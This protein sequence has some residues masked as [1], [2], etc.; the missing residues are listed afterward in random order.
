MPLTRDQSLI[1]IFKFCQWFRY[2]GHPSETLFHIVCESLLVEVYNPG[3]K[4]FM[5][6][7]G[8]TP[9]IKLDRD[10]DE[11]ITGVGTG[12]SFSGNAEIF[13]D[14]IPGIRCISEF[15]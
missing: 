9:L 7:I 3:R 6:V 5:K 12:G 2:P 15:S 14:A 11:F 8:K 1:I 10:F 13:K 4:L